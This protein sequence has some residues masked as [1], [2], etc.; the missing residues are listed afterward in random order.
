VLP[1]LNVGPA[2]SKTKAYHSLKNEYVRLAAFSCG[3]K[4][5][6]EQENEQR[7]HRPNENKMSDVHRERASLEVKR[8]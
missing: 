3:N 4:W 7:T 6:G 8:F 2:V 1:L 5:Q